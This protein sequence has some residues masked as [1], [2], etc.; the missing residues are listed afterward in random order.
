[1]VHGACLRTAK[2]SPSESLQKQLAD[3]LRAKV[4]DEFV[5]RRSDTEWFL[6]GDFNAYV[7]QIRQPHIWGGEPELLMSSHVLQMPIT[8]YMW[9]KNS[10]TLK[11][12]A[13]YGQEYGKDDPIRILYHGYG[14]YDAL[15]CPLGATELNL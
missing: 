9:D 5:K 7:L 11:I 12:I 6:E 1:M 10:S 14:H 13:E 3:E 4:A 15:E 8:V 2:S